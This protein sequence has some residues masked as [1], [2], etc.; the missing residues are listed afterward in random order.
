MTIR[1][2]A[3]TVLATAATAGLLAACGADDATVPAQ[4]PAT[5]QTSPA[6]TPDATG[7]AA[8]GTPVAQANLMDAAGEG[9]GTVTFSDDDGTM[10]VRIDANGLTPGFHGFHVHAIGKCEADSPDPAD[11]TNTGDFLSSG[12]HLPGDGAEHPDHAG[13][14]PVLQVGEDGT[15]T[16]TTRTDRLTR[17]LLFDDD[18]SAVVVHDGADN[19][20]NIPTRYASAGADDETKKAGDAGSRVLC[21]VVEEAS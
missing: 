12:G 9:K 7:D 13:D 14:L 18:G 10:V 3:V 19:Y 17:E 15:G 21:G 11:P 8:E 2:A 6:A 4:A 5:E 20:A 1:K 16:L